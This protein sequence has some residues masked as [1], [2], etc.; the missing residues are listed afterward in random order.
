MIQNGN[1]ASICK[2]PAVTLTERDKRGSLPWQLTV[3]LG[4]KTLRKR[5]KDA[6]DQSQHSRTQRNAQ[7]GKDIAGTVPVSRGVQEAGG[8]SNWN[9]HSGYLGFRR[10]IW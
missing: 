9:V 2:A 1:L 5:E 4:I 3:F 8:E 7:T 10:W 6:H